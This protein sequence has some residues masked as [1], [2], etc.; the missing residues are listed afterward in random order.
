MERAQDLE[1]ETLRKNLQREID[2]DQFQSTVE[3]ELKRLLELEKN[4]EQTI[5]QKCQE[6]IQAEQDL[7]KVNIDEITEVLLKEGL[8]TIPRDID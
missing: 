1:M 6:K 3:S 8:A 5:K 7:N 2:A 4:W